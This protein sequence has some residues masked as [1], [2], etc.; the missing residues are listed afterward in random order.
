MERWQMAKYQKKA[1][2]YYSTEILHVPLGEYTVTFNYFEILDES[3][4]EF[5]HMHE[6]YEV[7]YCLEG[8]M[9][10]MIN[11]TPYVLE[12]NHF[13]II[14]PG[15]MHYNLY[16]PRLQKRYMVLVFEEP[17]LNAA[18]TKSA[19]SEEMNR[20]VRRAIEEIEGKQCLCHEDQYR[21]DRLILQLAEE[22]AGE[23]PG[24]QE[25]ISTYY[26]QILVNL[27]RNLQSVAE[28]TAV[29]QDK[30][31]GNRNLALELTRFMHENYY[32]NITVSDAAQALSI[33]ERHVGRIFT[34]Y[35]GES[36]KRTLNI[37]RIN[38]AK[39]YLLDTNDSI[40]KI[41]A[42]VGIS[43]TKKFHQLFRELEGVSAAEYRETH[44]KQYNHIQSELPPAGQKN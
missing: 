19:A 4:V 28:L 3:C 31:S 38:Y 37:Y 36:F 32:R 44:K 10:L 24:H 6:D 17:A 29:P 9:H 1:T 26:C 43:S 30:R 21:C 2:P 39:N 35:F 27:C 25:M 42:R 7:Y 5:A 40:E 34:K 16:E 23:L 15:M 8:S 13:M 33:S 11:D 14:N 18:R 12:K 22:L 20:F 41:A